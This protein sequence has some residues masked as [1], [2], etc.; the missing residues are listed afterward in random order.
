M[1]VNYFP[2]RAVQF[3]LSGKPIAIF[4][5]AH[6]LGEVQYAIGGRAVTEREIAAVFET[7]KSKG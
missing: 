3:D 2:D 7:Q 5:R 1:I 6:R 4:D